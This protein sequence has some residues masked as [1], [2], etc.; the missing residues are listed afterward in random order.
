MAVAVCRVLPTDAV[1]QAT[2]TGT[3]GDPRTSVA[4]PEVS[5][6]PSAVATTSIQATL[7]AAAEP[8]GPDQ[9]R[10]LEVR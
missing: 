3:G 4:Q 7:G 1:T 9:I 8:S 2:N 10:L 6:E 5:G